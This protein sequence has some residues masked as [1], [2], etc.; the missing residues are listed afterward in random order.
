ME[1]ILKKVLLSRARKTPRGFW[2]IKAYKNNSTPRKLSY[3]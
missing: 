3:K 2:K 1:V